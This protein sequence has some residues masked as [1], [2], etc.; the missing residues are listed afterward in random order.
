[1]ILYE[2]KE[3]IVC[4][5]P[6]KVAVQSARIGEKDLV[7]MLNNH[8]AEEAERK[9]SSEKRK[10][11]PVQ[12]VFVVH[13]LDQPVEGIV[14][15]GKTKRAAAHLSKQIT[16]GSMKKIY[17]AVCCV[18]EAGRSR[19]ENGETEAKLVDYLVKDGR[20]NTSFL[21]KKGQK[22]AKEARLTYRILDRIGP[23]AFDGQS[24]GE[25]GE[26]ATDQISCVLAEIH[27]DTGR[28]HQIRVQMANAG[29]PL[30]GDSKYNPQWEQYAKWMQGSGAGQRRLA[31]PALCA[32]ELSFIHPTTG[33]VMHF[34][35]EPKKESFRMFASSNQM[36]EE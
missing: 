10:S 15:F 25:E 7:S 24:P 11:G 18:T 9:N 4:H 12:T 29:L 36:A 3:L 6:A 8:L 2:D 33:K 28:H 14:V 30:Y 31:D 5:K 1:M 21:A 23:K 19:I 13:R 22:D 34:K 35:T 20:T 27:L 32:A 16:D 26:K 17:R